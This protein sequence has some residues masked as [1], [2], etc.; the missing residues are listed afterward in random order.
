VAWGTI[1]VMGAI[2]TL[3]LGFLLG[4]LADELRSRRVSKSSKQE[5]IA[6]LQMD[7]CAELQ[8]L[9][10]PFFRASSEL[11]HLNAEVDLGKVL[12]PGR[13]AKTDAHRDA[14]ER[15]A[16]LH[17]RAVVLRSRIRD[18]ELRLDVQQTIWHVMGYQG[19]VTPGG[20]APSSDD[21]AAVSKLVI[22]TT[23]R[24]GDKVRALSESAA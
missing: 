14:T 16:D 5:R 24:L 8:E 19:K 13:S 23:E 2:V 4:L 12:A 9:L 22:E 20:S 15:Y 7:T 18:S 11:A 3:V 21:W 10:R 6:R 17:S 1:W